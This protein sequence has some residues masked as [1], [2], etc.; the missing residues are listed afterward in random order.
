MKTFKKLI[1]SIAVATIVSSS[2]FFGAGAKAAAAN[3]SLYTIVSGD[4]LWLISQKYGT[5]VSELMNA[6]NLKSYMIYP[7]QV[8]KIPS[9]ASNQKS[10]E[11]VYWLSRIIEAEASGESYT[12]KVAVGNVIMNRKASNE[13]PNT[14]KGV[15]FESYNGIPQFS[16]VAEGTI[17]NTPSASSINA[18]L[19]AINGSRVVG[20][21]TYFFNPDKSSG[22]WI[23]NNKTY[24]TR[25][26]NHVFYR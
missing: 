16:P 24:V 1:C 13:F 2:L 15:I 11:D 7:N 6:N 4:S 20:A 9:N 3:Y 10:N 21:S 12:G 25:I 22:S 18:A 23:V 8:L 14:I 26:G 19:D 5:T 17:Y